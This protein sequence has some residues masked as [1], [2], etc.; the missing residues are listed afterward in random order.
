MC[1]LHIYLSYTSAMYNDIPA[2]IHQSDLLNPCSAEYLKM[3]FVPILNIYDAVIKNIFLNSI[4]QP[5]LNQFPILI[6]AI[7]SNNFY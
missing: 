4:A 7:L 1:L 2:K 5:V 3:F 6:R